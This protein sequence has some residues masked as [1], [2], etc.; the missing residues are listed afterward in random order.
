MSESKRPKIRFKGFTEE[1]EERKLRDISTVTAGGDINRSKM[2]MKGKYPVIANSLANDGIVGYYETDF[3]IKAPALTVTGRGEVGHAKSRKTNFTPVV[4]LLSIQTNHDVDFL[5]NVINNFRIVVESTG[6]PQLTIPHLTNYIVSIPNISEERII[7]LFFDKVN[8]YISLNQQKLDKLK[9]IKIAMLEKMF[10]KE[11][12]LV[13]EI[14]FEEFIGEW[15]QH[16]LIEVADIVGGGTP[17]TLKKEYWNGAIDWYSPTEIGNKRYLS[18]S[19]KQISNLGLNKSSAKILPIGTVLFTSRAGIGNT[20]ILLK[21]GTTNQGF[22]SIIPKKQLLNTYF[23]YCM[24]NRLKRY[25]EVTGAGSTFVEVSGKQMAEMPLSIPKLIEQ[26]KIGS[27]FKQLDDT[28]D[29]HQQKLDKLKNIK[30]S[31]LEKMFV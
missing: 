26:T 23:I 22:Q 9:D 10:P 6:V 27:F 5:E 28:I 25:G 1:W 20:A 29:L 18:K 21:E 24:S 19:Q 14:R 31:L 17:S 2:S 30:K 11:G 16:K 13:P 15:E 3:Q 7:G 4:R 8:S 12:K